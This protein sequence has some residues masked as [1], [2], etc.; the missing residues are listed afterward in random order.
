MNLAKIIPL[1]MSLAFLFPSLARS[2]GEITTMDTSWEEISIG[3]KEC[4]RRAKMA[5]K[6]GGFAGGLVVVKNTSVFGDRGAYIASVRC[7]ASKQMVFFVV[8]GP[9]ADRV[10]EYRSVLENQ[11]NLSQ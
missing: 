11:F 6:N 2:A 5:I 3:Q 1:S 7:F 8:A 10:A 4:V 9:S